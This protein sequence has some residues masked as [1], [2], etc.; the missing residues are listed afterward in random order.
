MKKVLFNKVE[1]LQKDSL[2]GELRPHKTIDQ[3]ETL[4]F[5]VGSTFGKKNL[6]HVYQ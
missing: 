4:L 2:A 1:T 5:L 6:S 3:Q